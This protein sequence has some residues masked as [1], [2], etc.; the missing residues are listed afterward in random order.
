MIYRHQMRV[1]FTKLV[2]DTINVFHAIL[3][4]F[5]IMPK[6]SHASKC[7]VI[8]GIS[9]NIFLSNPQAIYTE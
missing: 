8:D 2:K 1:F 3:D 7:S 6:S 4:Y 5:L 9:L